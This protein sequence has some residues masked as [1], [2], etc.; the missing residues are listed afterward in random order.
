ME[1]IFNLSLKLLSS[2]TKLSS[3]DERTYLFPM[4]LCVLN[5]AALVNNASRCIEKIN[6]NVIV[7]Q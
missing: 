5:A 4:S 7:I 6:K 2:A 1:F 3:C